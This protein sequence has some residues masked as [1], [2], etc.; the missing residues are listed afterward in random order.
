[1]KKAL[2][3]CIFLLTTHLLIYSQVNE[4][5]LKAYLLYYIIDYIDYPKEKS[6]D[7]FTIGFFG[8]NNVM[9]EELTRI[10]IAKKIK[11]KSIVIKNITDY[12]D[13]S[14][15]D[16]LYVTESQNNNIINLFQPTQKHHVLLVTEYMSNNQFTMINLIKDEATSKISF[17][18]NKQN[19]ISARLDYKPELLIYGGTELD[20]R[21]LYITTQTMLESESKNVLKLL[22]ENKQREIELA[23]KNYQIDLLESNITQANNVLRPLQD[24][25]LIHKKNLQLTNSLLA[26][27][28]LEYDEVQAKFNNL[29]STFNQLNNK[30]SLQTNH[31]SEL[32]KII[33]E[34]ESV[35][36]EQSK[37]IVQKDDKLQAERKNIYLTGLSSIALLIIGLLLLL[38]YRQK[39]KNN[40]LLENKVAT[41]TQ[42]LKQTNEQLLNEIDERQKFEKELLAS[43]QNYRQIFNATTEA[44]FIHDAT[45]G[46]ILDVNDPMLQLYGYKRHQIPSFKLSDFCSGL[47]NY[48]EIDA[49]THIQDAIS[50]GTT[51]FE[52]QAKRSDGTFFWTEVSLKSTTIRSQNRIL[53]VVRD[54]DNLK[55]TTVELDKYRKNLERLVKE[56]T[57]E[58]ESSNRELNST[59]ERMNQLNIDLQI[60]KD[61]LEL[62]INELTDARQQLIQSEK[63]ASLG[64][65]SAG[66][67]HEINNPVN[68]ISSGASALFQIIN[69][70]KN[71]IDISNPS[72]KEYFDEIFITQSA[73]ETGIERTTAII[74]SLRNYS[75]SNDNQFI[76]YN[77]INCINDSLLLMHNSYKYHVNIQTKMPDTLEVDCMPGR[78]N[79][80]FV[81]LISNA[82]HAIEKDGVILIEATKTATNVLIKIT[83]NGCGMSQET[84]DKIFDPFFTTKSV[85]KGTGLGL[86][87]VHGIIEEHNGN[88]SVSSEVGKGTTFTITLPL[89]QKSTGLN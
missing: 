17:L 19:I 89:R 8:N 54:I 2:T 40:L 27:R 5:R 35:I 52:W 64:V 88:I 80:L 55:Q 37:T 26:Q 83:D 68:F 62:T 14:M 48:T 87:I 81:N 41:R 63:L 67:A 56:R 7:T 84:I 43:E 86:Y 70:L 57:D 59:L 6:T 23:E 75:R 29:N 12:S 1:M 10:G 24:T 82:T 33:A 42:E 32:D 45:D 9:Q 78:I 47:P 39:R 20:V 21:E 22:Q 76:K 61:A 38:A 31:L 66:I 18:V 16:A 30:I 73:I 79:Q 53:A 28:Q 49:I 58:L 74:S 44:I 50:N 69:A 72:I 71:D 3:F 51:T 77:I 34:R 11:G 4:D 25:I 36:R 85:G 13:L 46:K 15:L 60:Q 65:F